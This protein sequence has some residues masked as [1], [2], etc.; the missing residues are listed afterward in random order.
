MRERE[1]SKSFV[2]FQLHY[3]SSFQLFGVLLFVLYLPTYTFFP[4]F[5]H[6]TYVWTPFFCSFPFF[7]ISEVKLSSCK[8]FR[9]AKKSVCKKRGGRK[10]EFFE[11]F[12]P[13]FHQIFCVPRRASIDWDEVD[14][15]WLL[16]TN[17]VLFRS[18]TCNI[19]SIHRRYNT[20]NND[21]WEREKVAA[22]LQQRKEKYSTKKRGERCQ[23]IVEIIEKKSRSRQK[24]IFC[25]KLIFLS[26]N[27]AK[28]GSRQQL[29]YNQ[30]V[31]V[32]MYAR[33]YSGR[34]LMRPP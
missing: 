22:T 34:R 27:C 6:Y 8:F 3:L 20:Y 33:R 30:I 12:P 31:S 14:W 17:S 21:G 7:L 28:K 2:S 32:C 26:L 9:K 4:R 13:F 15:R 5:F 29:L 19:F 25:A 23:K 10:S 1:R 18:K 24:Y 11:C 16:Q